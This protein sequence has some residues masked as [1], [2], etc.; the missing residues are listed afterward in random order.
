MPLLTSLVILAVQLV[1]TLVCIVDA[2]RG[3]CRMIE[4]LTPLCVYISHAIRQRF[5]EASSPNGSGANPSSF[6]NVL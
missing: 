6:K 3:E 4:I 2:Q 1:L 5:F